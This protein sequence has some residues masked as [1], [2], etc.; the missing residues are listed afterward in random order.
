MSVVLYMRAV[1]QQR[2]KKELTPAKLTQLLSDRQRN[3]TN[4]QIICLLNTTLIS[5]NRFKSFKYRFF[6]FM[7]FLVY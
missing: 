6:F 1:C 5:L 4:V 3:L 2:I 7:L